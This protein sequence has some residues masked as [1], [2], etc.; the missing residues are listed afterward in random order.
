MKSGRAKM[1]VMA[2]VGLLAVIGI[3]GL[4]MNWEPVY[5]G[6]TLSAWLDQV[7]ATPG[8]PMITD[9]NNPA[10]I[11]V[12]AI[13]T[14]AIPFLMRDL[15]ARDNPFVHRLEQLMLKQ[16]VIKVRFWG[17]AE[18]R[19][20]ALGGFRALNTIGA[21]AIPALVSLVETNPGYIPAVLAG[22]GR[23]ALPALA[24]CLTNDTVYQTPFG[25]FRF[26]PGNTIEALRSGITLD[27]LRTR[28]VEPLLP[29][30]RSWAVQSTNGHAALEANR[31]LNELDHGLRLAHP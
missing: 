10:V 4:F 19:N 13:G 26:I 23:P 25:P 27:S 18:R 12:R 1:S 8:S 7:T 3:C 14:N 9:T 31:F 22:I 17:A 28:D 15:E 21:P 2:V 11:A 5:Q 24:Q 6:V 30:I 20:R 29:V 16:K